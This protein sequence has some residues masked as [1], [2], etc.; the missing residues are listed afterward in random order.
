LN[1]SLTNIIP[2]AIRPW[3]YKAYLYVKDRYQVYIE[4]RNPMVPPQWK[5]FV[6]GGNFEA[7]GKVFFNY[8]KELG[9]LKPDDKVLDVGC[10]Q[11][12]MAIPLTSYLQ[13]GE[14]EGLDIVE[15]GI[16]WCKKK[17]TLKHK[18]FN[19][20]L[21]D[22]YNRYYN[23]KGKYKSSEYNFPYRDASFDFI[24]MT[25]VFTHMLP[26]EVENYLKETSRVLKPGGRC[27][28][29][30][31]ILNEESQKLIAENQSSLDFKFEYANYTTVDESLPE[32]GV[33]F[34]ESYIRSLYEKNGLSLVQPLYFGNWCG[35]KDF[36]DY[37]DII[38]AAKK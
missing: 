15:Q 21:A 6:G 31:F 5:I 17:I 36:L 37:Q 18:N 24:F 10:G 28:I 33:G 16:K 25:S 29:T 26:S 4:K 19:F 14:Y 7:I 1:K 34:N 20:Q 12:R 35:R 30:W 27:L 23:P 22:I 38:L 32:I 13:K 9:Q 8:F 2:S 11:G 3:V